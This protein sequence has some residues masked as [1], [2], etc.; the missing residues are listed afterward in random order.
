MRAFFLDRDGVIVEDPAFV[1]VDR[2]RILARAVEGIKKLNQL[3][4]VIVVTNQPAIAR[5]VLTENELAILHEKMKQEFKEV[6]AKIDAIYYCP[7]H[8]ERNHSDIAPGVMKYRIEC[9]CRKPKI[10]LLERAAKDFSLDLNKCFIIGDTS[11]DIKAGAEAGC[12][13]ILLKT[14]YGGTDNKYKVAPDFVAEDLE[15]AADLIEINLKLKALILAGGRGERMRQLTD[16]LP[17]P[18]LPV[19][20]KPVIQH[21]IELLRKHGI[22]KIVIAGHY[23]FEVIKNYFGSGEKFGVE[24]EYCD[25]EIPL[26]TGGAIRNAERFLS[27]VESFVVL[28]GDV[29]TEIDIKSLFQFHKNKKALATLVLRHTDHPYDSDIVEVDRDGRVKK[30]IGKGQKKSDT[31]NT[32]NFVFQKEILNFIPKGFCI[33]E[34]DVL[35]QLC[36]SENIYGYLASEYTKD[37]GTPE[38]YENVKKYFENKL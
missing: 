25:E 1:K 2:L 26:G 20:G 14:G 22:I 37:M 38:R 19:A 4:L 36:D 12:Q 10:G 11:R 7:H 23:L 29:M 24:I 18:M 27:E 32:G 17:K 33:I 9:Q 3:G 31:A 30:I 34:K 5:N 15:E 16:K 8:P 35:S 6:G 21:Q 28:S 13:T